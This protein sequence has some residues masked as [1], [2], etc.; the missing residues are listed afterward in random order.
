[1]ISGARAQL[2]IVPHYHL[3]QTV[4]VSKVACVNSQHEGNYNF[5]DI[6]LFKHK[7]RITV[8]IKLCVKL[9]ITGNKGL[10]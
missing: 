5:G 1:M 8:I 4:K 2:E 9:E 3:V 7:V 10:K 6:L